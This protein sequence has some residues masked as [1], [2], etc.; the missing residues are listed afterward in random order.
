MDSDF[1]KL[2]EKGI[3][4]NDA[5]NVEISTF[6]LYA[7]VLLLVFIEHTLPCSFVARPVRKT[8]G[9]TGFPVQISHPVNKSLF[10]QMIK[11]LGMRPTEMEKSIIDMAYSLIDQGFVKRTK[12]YNGNQSKDDEEKL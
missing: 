3:K 5:R 8:S 10:M 11:E 9:N 2:L 6:G 4:G 1:F 12:D 7:K